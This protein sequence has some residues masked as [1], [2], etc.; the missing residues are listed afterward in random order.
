MATLTFPEWLSEQQD[1]GDEVA[2]FAKEVAHLT[3][4]PESGGKAIYDG[5]FETALP[6]L[7]T[8]FERA[9]EEFAAHPEPSAS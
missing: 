4:F 9:W 7:R 3:D 8:V 6:A 5:Y 1:R 2:A